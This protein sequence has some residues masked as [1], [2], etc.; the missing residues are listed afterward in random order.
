MVIS[1]TANI[2][3]NPEK[4]FN[5]RKIK[6]QPQYNI[7]METLTRDKLEIIRDTD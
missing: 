1:K 5:N 2:L 3:K 7:P 6:I 4:L